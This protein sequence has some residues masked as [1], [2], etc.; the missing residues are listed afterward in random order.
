MSN[1][2]SEVPQNFRT[3]LKNDRWS[4]FR[5][6]AQKE[7]VGSATIDIVK[8]VWVDIGRKQPKPFKGGQH[9]VFHVFNYVDPSKMFVPGWSGCR[10]HDYKKPFVTLDEALAVAAKHAAA[11]LESKKWVR[12]DD[13]PQGK[14]A[15]LKRLD[16]VCSQL[17]VSQVVLIG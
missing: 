4:C 17:G 2:P 5:L 16:E 12:F 6:Y 3:E 7:N 9:P 1:S 11:A 15:R 14:R 10:V 13:L 8:E